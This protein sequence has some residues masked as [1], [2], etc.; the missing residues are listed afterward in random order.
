MTGVQTCAL[1]ICPEV[2]F[3]SGF[4]SDEDWEAWEML[5]KRNG[6]FVYCKK[7][8]TL[9]RI[10]ED[11]ETSKILGDNARIKEDYVMFCKFWPKFIAKIL[12]K[13]Y[14]T[15]EKSNDL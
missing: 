7:P 2:V 6:A 3:K 4:R 13:V 5:S 1:P 14:G 9:H 10:H 8:L 15:S 11:S 12:T